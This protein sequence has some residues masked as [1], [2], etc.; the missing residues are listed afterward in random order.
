MKHF[1]STKEPTRLAVEFSLME[2]AFIYAIEFG[3]QY[4]QQEELYLSFLGKREPD[5]LFERITTPEGKTSLRFH[6]S[7]DDN[8]EMVI[9]RDVLVKNLI[10]PN[11]LALK[12]IATLENPLLEK[13]TDAFL[14]FKNN[15]IIVT[16]ERKPIAL[17]HLLDVDENFS[18]FVADTI[19]S[20]D[21]GINKF[22]TYKTPIEKFF[23]ENNKKEIE[24]VMKK[25]VSISQQGCSFSN[26][27]W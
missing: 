1:H 5:L 2:T 11:F 18:S 8:K 17:P 13:I 16:P 3:S 15:L 26:P 12:I 20:F 25:N 22:I 6:D 10:K 27:R 24:N 21:L 14:W 23:G 7:L 19:T 9:L 4:V